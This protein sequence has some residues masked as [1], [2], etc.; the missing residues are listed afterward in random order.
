M[1]I[2]TDY[3]SNYKE[4]IY[5]EV[6]VFLNADTDNDTTNIRVSR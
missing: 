6:H 4:V 3:A 5:F 1:S 2:W